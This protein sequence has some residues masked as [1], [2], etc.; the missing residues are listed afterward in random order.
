MTVSLAGRS[1]AARR[2]PSTLGA[3]AAAVVVAA[4]LALFL[5]AESQLAVAALLAVG[6]V[7]AVGAARTG[8]GRATVEVFERRPAL[9]GLLCVA[10]VAAETLLFAERHFVLLMLATY[11]LY[12]TVGLGLTVQFGYAGTLNF[13]GASFYGVGA[14]TAAV[15]GSVPGFPTLLAIPLGGITAALVGGLLIAPV[16]RTR[17]HYAAVVTIAFALLF[18]T[19]LEVNEVLGGP[20]GM[21]VA[22]LSVAGYDFALPVSPWP[23]VEWSFYVNYVA[24]ALVLALLAYAAT[25]RIEHSW[26]G[27][28]MDAVRTDEIAA[29]CFGV[30]IE[31]TK[32]VAFVAGNVLI[33]MAGAL[34]GTMVGF[35]APNNFTFADSL[36]FLTVLLLGGLGSRLGLL[37]AAAVVVFLPEKLQLIQEYRFL[38]FATLVL[39]VLMFRPQGL[40]PRPP[41]TWPGIGDRG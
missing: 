29:S 10:V 41:R 40:V 22:S 34:Y 25:R 31:R 8:V 35:I 9:A 37:V 16:L 21:L 4:Y 36:L 33:G 28:G 12:V 23:G 17:G 30:G 26:L 11:L 7:A 18:K 20:Q 27:L 19:F 3:L 39:V 24:A 13:A 2:A 5:E 32:I 1:P 38:L 6:A 14:Y 15:L